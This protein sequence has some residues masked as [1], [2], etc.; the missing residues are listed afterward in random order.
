MVIR[1]DSSG[2]TGTP[3]DYGS[4][5]NN[6]TNTGSTGS[7]GTAVDS[8]KLITG[9][10]IYGNPTYGDISSY[11][12]QLSDPKFAADIRKKLVAANK[13]GKGS[14]SDT[15]L[16][17]AYIQTLVN[18]RNVG[19]TWDE[20]MAET[21]QQNAYQNILSGTGAPTARQ[22]NAAKATVDSYAV[23]LGVTLDDA[24]K[25]K[26]VNEFAGGGLP[27]DVLKQRIAQ[28][29]KISFETGIAATTVA[30]LKSLASDYGVQY[31]ND[32]F[33]QAA[34]SVLQGKITNDA[35]IQQIKDLSKSYY[36]AFSNQIDAGLTPAKIASPYINSMANVLELN[37]A[38]ISLND[39]TIRKALTSIDDKGTPVAKPIW[40]FEQDL[41]NDSRW[42]F[43]NNAQQD[44]MGTAHKVLRDFGLVS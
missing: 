29:G 7:T 16:Q 33:N 19:K 35:L 3:G 8:T 10:D 34:T 30:S 11:V 42:K 9:Y 2:L 39:P 23:D 21:T 43:T 6:T 18:A 37:P 31:N 38:E 36:P 26:L 40:Q 28:S 4:T 15:A 20:W 5:S 14:K 32:W 1:S 24:S 13:I 44:L 41:R 17:K 22:I 27:A 12:K 25:K